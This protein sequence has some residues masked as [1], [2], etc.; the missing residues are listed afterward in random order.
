MHSNFCRFTFSLLML[1]TLSSKA[2]EF[3]FNTDIISK[4]LTEKDKGYL[5][6][7]KS[8]PGKYDVDIYINGIFIENKKITFENGKN[9]SLTPYL[10]RR[11]II[12]WGVDPKKIDSK[13]KTDTVDLI[14]NKLIRMNLDLNNSKVNFSVPQELLITEYN[15]IS[16]VEVWDDGINAFVMNYSLGTNQNEYRGGG[17]SKTRSSWGQFSPGVN[18][19]AWRVRNNSTWQHTDS[20]ENTWKSNSTYAERGL[21]NVKSRL[22]VG[23]RNSPSDVLDSI[24]FTGVMLATD[25]EMVPYSQRE[26]SPM[27]RGIAR[28]A[29]RVEIKQNGYSIYNTNVPPGP[30]EINTI[31]QAQDGGDLEVTVWETDGRPQVFIVPYQKPAISLHQGFVKYSVMSGRYH[32]AGFH[33]KQD[34]TQGT[35]MVG[36]P[37]NLTAFGGGDVAESYKAATLGLGIS[38]GNLGSVSVDGTQAKSRFNHQE[39]RSGNKSRLR[40]S[41]TIVATN[42]QI[43]ATYSDYSSEYSDIT[44]VFDSY[45]TNSDKLLRGAYYQHRSSSVIQ[46]SQGVGGLG[47]LTASLQ[48]DLWRDRKRTESYRLSWSQSFRYFSMTADWQR[49]M[50][51]LDHN[52]NNKDDMFSVRFYFQ[53]DRWLGN[54]IQAST[55]FNSPGK[56]QQKYDIGLNGQSFDRQLSW[57]VRTEYDKNKDSLSLANHLA[58]AEW[59]GSYG[60]VG[61]SYNYSSQYRNISASLS[62]GV[63]AHHH[64]VTFGQPFTDSV[65]LAETPGARGVKVGGWPGIK[66]DFRGYTILPYLSNYQ[67]NLVKLDTNS[68]S[69]DAEILQSESRAVPTQGAVIE[70]RFKTKIGAKAL[71]SITN[72]SGRKLPLG[73]E[74][75][76][77]DQS[78]IA[79]VV[80]DNGEAYLSGLAKEGVLKAVTPIKNCIINYTLSETQPISGIYNLAAV[81]K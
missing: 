67:S 58:S 65:V 74:I 53:L 40:Y 8:K 54:S 39:Q 76:V 49:S 34:I 80:D 64:G 60:K 63:I 47:T 7:G 14:S 61:G 36:L 43:S 15:D 48:K 59:A 6:S 32:P 35:V 57:A 56:G 23:Q 1:S 73:T 24:P 22:V 11:D 71:F 33:S 18:I 69:K 68:L 12:K 75:Y 30:F 20:G 31:T 77:Q 52:G 81:C 13:S 41:N 16:P 29:A 10:N 72:S 45:G 21:Y 62:G 51:A 9:G 2:E 4:N 25:D 79:G 70:M 55:G 26:F 37:W 3:K 50:N 19:G 66:T 38:F 42:T 27:V 46:F 5:I 28:T 78:G 17:S 44:D